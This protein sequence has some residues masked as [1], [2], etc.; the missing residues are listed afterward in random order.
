M[1]LERYPVFCF[2]LC[3]LKALRLGMRMCALRWSLIGRKSPH[4]CVVPSNSR[5]GHV[6]GGILAGVVLW[7]GT[8]KEPIY[9]GK[10]SVNRTQ[11]P[12]LV[13]RVTEHIRCLYHPGLKDANGLQCWLLRRKLW[14]I[15][16]S[17]VNFSMISQNSGRGSEPPAREAVGG[18]LAQ[19]CCGPSSCRPGL[20]QTCSISR[21]AGSG[22]SF[23]F[24][25]YTIFTEHAYSG[26]QAPLNLFDPR[27]LGLFL[28]YCAK[29]SSRP[30]FPW[31]RLPRWPRWRIASC[32]R[33]A[34]RLVQAWKIEGGSRPRRRSWPRYFSV[35]RM[36]PCSCWDV[37]CGK[38]QVFP[39]VRL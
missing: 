20:G 14:R 33:G 28:A 30:N 34:S 6:S 26:S 38:S 27:R 13:A 22:Q 19:L 31:I 3:G 7:V 21:S 8:S 17:L 12:A 32:L 18:H 9:T 37:W 16:F 25:H 35:S 36:S 39:V 1:G 15:G 23:F 5:S 11:Y 24:R 10:A 2:E 4:R 29:G